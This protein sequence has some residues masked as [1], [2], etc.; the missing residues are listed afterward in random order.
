MTRQDDWQELLD[1]GAHLIRLRGKRPIAGFP[2]KS[3]GAT[4]EEIAE[5]LQKHPD[6]QIG[7]VPASVQAV[8]VD[9]DDP[10][11][12]HQAPRYGPELC[13]YATPSGGTH[14]WQRTAEALPNSKWAGGDIRGRHG[15]VVLWP[16]PRALAGN[17]WVA[18]RPPESF[19]E[20]SAA[21]PES[22]LPPLG[23]EGLE[24]AARTLAARMQRPDWHA[25]D[26]HL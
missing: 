9:V 10:A 1:Q 13:R 7:I 5:H 18:Y 22:G 25:V 21:E 19:P 4:L 11:L 3:R 15:Y 23:P 24:A 16:G 2:W 12:L 6:A 17:A 8:V 20:P 14:I 26:L